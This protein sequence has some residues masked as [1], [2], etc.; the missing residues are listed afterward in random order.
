MRVRSAA[1]SSR[2]S[3]SSRRVRTPDRQLRSLVLYVGLVGTY[4]RPVIYTGIWTSPRSPAVR[5]VA[6]VEDEILQE[7][8]SV[9][10]PHKRLMA[11]GHP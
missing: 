10:N 2:R 4:A 8:A 5:R 9:Q 7:Q 3:A 1:K 11:C 6:Q